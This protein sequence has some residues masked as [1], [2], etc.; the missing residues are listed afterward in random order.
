MSEEIVGSDRL[1]RP[2]RTDHRAAARSR[3]GLV[4]CLLKQETGDAIG[5]ASVA[6]GSD[7]QPNDAASPSRSSFVLETKED[8]PVGIEGIGLI[9]F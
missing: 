2:G 1:A 8:D 6:G 9:P 3:S 7:G 5:V 4:R